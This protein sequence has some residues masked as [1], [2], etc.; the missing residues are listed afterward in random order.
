[1]REYVETVGDIYGGAGDA[2]EGDAVGSTGKKT[3]VNT[4]PGSVGPG[5]DFGGTAVASKGGVQNQDG[6]SAPSTDKAQEIKSGNV[7]VPGGK[8]AAKPA[9]VAPKTGEESGV[10]D[11]P[12]QKQNT[13]SK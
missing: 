8:A 9:G 4:K 13:G 2:T 5:A 11:K 10:N 1:M 6:T 12:V 7:N 3:S